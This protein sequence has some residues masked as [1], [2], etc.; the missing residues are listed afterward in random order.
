MKQFASDLLVYGS[1]AAVITKLQ[2]KMIE[3]KRLA[4]RSQRL[5]QSRVSLPFLKTSRT[6]NF[7][8]DSDF[9]KG[10]V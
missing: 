1:A 4:L 3:L 5:F 9:V 2:I 10:D 8:Q 6:L 7:A